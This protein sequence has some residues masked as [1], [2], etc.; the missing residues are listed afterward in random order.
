MTN[1]NEV[2]T[3]VTK[4]PSLPVAY[5]AE[6]LED[7]FN[8]VKAEV[9]TNVPDLETV[10]GRKHIKALAAKISS[11]KTAIDKPMR[12]YLREI[13]ALPKVV[14]KNARESVERFDALRDATLK[15]LADAQASQDAI[16]ERM[17]EIVRL[18]SQDGLQSDTVRLLWDEINA[19]QIEST[20]WPE[21]IKKAK[22]SYDGA[23]AV[24]DSTLARIIREEAQSAELERLRKES[25]ENAQRERDRQIAEAAVLKAREDERQRA[26]QRILDERNKAEQDRLAK[27]KAEQDKAA[28]E[29]ALK[30]AEEKAKRD[31]ELAEQQAKERERIAA[32]NAKK[33]A[34]EQQ[35]LEAQ[36]LKDEEQ[37]RAD[38]KQHRVAINREILVAIIIDE[39]FCE[40]VPE[41]KREDVAKA[42]ITL[43][44]KRIAGKM[45][46]NY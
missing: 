3:E 20:F 40:L 26:E 33:Y 13:K 30:D 9:E 19:V 35:A 8:K 16:I 29:Q 43:A 14:E 17:D 22:A 23:V 31:A 15:P 36:R 11:S 18:C 25:E 32:E 6:S 2:S 39:K 37:R 7:L 12:D 45:V 24:V 34:E 46:V 5:T 42:V 38:D 4:L 44:A 27:L 1:K 41:D 28:A 21:L 10:E